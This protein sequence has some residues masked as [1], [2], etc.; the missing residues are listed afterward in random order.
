MGSFSP[1]SDELLDFEGL[2][3]KYGWPR[4]NERGY[5]IQEHLMGRSKLIRVIHIGAGMSGICW[6]KFLPE[7]LQNASLV[8]YDKNEDVGGTWF[9]NR[10]PGCACDIPSINYQVREELDFLCGDPVADLF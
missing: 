2:P 5:R 1:N 9:E 7:K 10:Y 6:T 8:V 4:E 3:D